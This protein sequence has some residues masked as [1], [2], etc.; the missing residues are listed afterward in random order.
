MATGGGRTPEEERAMYAGVPVF[1][2]QNDLDAATRRT[3]PWAS[4]WS[5]D[6]TGRA[7]ARIGNTIYEWDNDAG[8]GQVRTAPQGTFPT[9]AETAETGGIL[10]PL[11]TVNDGI[12]NP[13]PTGGITDPNYRS[14][15]EFFVGPTYTGP[16]TA[17]EYVLQRAGGPAWDYAYPMYIGAGV[18]GPG[19]SIPTVDSTG[20]W[21]IDTI[22]DTTTDTT[23]DTTTDDTTTTTT[24]TTDDDDTII[25]EGPD[26]RD[27]RVGTDYGWGTD[28]TP[29]SFPNTWPGIFNYNERVDDMGPTAAFGLLEGLRRTDPA[30]EMH[31]GAT[32]AMYGGAGDPGWAPES[33]I[34]QGVWGEDGTHSTFDPVSGKMIDVQH[35]KGQTK[36]SSF[37][38]MIGNAFAKTEGSK[39]WSP[40]KVKS[41]QQQVAAQP[42]TPSNVQQVIDIPSNV[43]WAPA[44]Q[45]VAPQTAPQVAPVVDIGLQAAIAEQ[46]RQ[47]QAQ[48]VQAAQDRM[49]QARQIMNSRD[50]QE[51]GMGNLSAAQRDIVAAAQIDTFGGG[52]LLGQGGYG[53]TEAEIAAAVATDDG[54][55]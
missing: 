16:T 24:T 13:S 4:S 34:Q 27:G 22:T 46:Q 7:K 36:G 6:P 49:R 21:I 8:W 15:G 30:F 39:A 38:G 17:D 45:P 32:E 20:D 29:P 54:F 25:A 1:T 47:Q 37:L 53:Q 33:T 40:E 31:P 18:Y 11:P 10:N 26:V 28:Q 14:L 55:Y 9:A 12:L 42:A 41:V 35:F 5:D 50:Y 51:G 43:T 2:D 3:S 23:S 52:G 48:E 19:R 44:A